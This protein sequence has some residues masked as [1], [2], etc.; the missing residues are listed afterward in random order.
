MKMLQILDRMTT[1]KV[2][3]HIIVEEQGSAFVRN[4]STRFVPSISLQF[5]IT[6]ILTT[7]LL[8]P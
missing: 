3:R 6:M 8:G 1:S 2:Q 7:A 5:L 4:S